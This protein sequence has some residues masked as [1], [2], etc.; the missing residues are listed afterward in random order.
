MHTKINLLFSN[1]A[2]WLAYRYFFLILLTNSSNIFVEARQW[3]YMPMFSQSE[4]KKF[5][6]YTQ[7][8]KYTY[9]QTLILL[10]VV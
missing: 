9:L 7:L 2:T 10:F 1:N 8:F 6:N 4:G 5:N 3:G